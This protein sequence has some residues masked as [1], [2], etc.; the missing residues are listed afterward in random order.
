VF[1][2]IQPRYSQIKVRITHKYVPLL[3]TSNSGKKNVNIRM[4]SLFADAG[5]TAAEF[6]GVDGAQSLAGQS[7]FGQVF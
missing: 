3:C 2:I 4:R 6:F 1:A 5:R 7:F